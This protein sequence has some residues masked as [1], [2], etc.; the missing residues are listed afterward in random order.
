[1]P[2]HIQMTK[3]STAAAEL[4]LSCR[5]LR[6]REKRYEM[7]QIIKPAADVQVIDLVVDPFTYHDALIA[8]V[9]KAQQD[10]HAIDHL[11]SVLLVAIAQLDAV[12]DAYGAVALA[13]LY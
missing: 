10:S 4:P 1:M 8:Y 11:A 13:G 9:S 6:L 3:L 2:A 12:G 7:D 5:W